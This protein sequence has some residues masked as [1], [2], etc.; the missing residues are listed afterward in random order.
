MF[1]LRP[2]DDYAHLGTGSTV[3]LKTPGRSR[4]AMAHPRTLMKENAASRQPFI[5]QTGKVGRVGA[6]PFTPNAKRPITELGTLSL[7]HQKTGRS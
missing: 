4:G 2:T 5:T 6:Y 1:S 7:V 3:P